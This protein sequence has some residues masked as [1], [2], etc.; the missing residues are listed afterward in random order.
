MT[1]IWP[2]YQTRLNGVAT[3]AGELDNY[4]ASNALNALYPTGT[5]GGTYHFYETSNAMARAGLSSTSSRTI[6]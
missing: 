3:V 6:A 4:N 1:S 5:S 2:L